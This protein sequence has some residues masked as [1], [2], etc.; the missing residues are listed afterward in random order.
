[1]TNFGLEKILYAEIID[2]ALAEDFGRGGDVTSKAVIPESRK[3]RA[4]II[5]RAEGRLAGIDVAL[6]AFHKLDP[7][8]ECL[9]I[10]EDGTRLVEGSVLV[11]IRGQTRAILSAER[12]ALNFLTHL[13]GIATLT[14]K[15]VDAVAG[16]GARIVDTRKTLPGLRVLEKYAVRCGGGF[17]HRSGLDDAILIKDNH[18]IAAG[19]VAEAIEACKKNLSHCRKIE[20]EVDTIA[21]L[22]SAL[23][24]APDIILLDNMEPEDLREAVAIIAGRAIAEASGGITLDSAAAIAAT[25]VDVL[26]IG[27]LTHSA[28]ALDLSLEL[29]DG[30]L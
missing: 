25:G 30:D 29:D 9:E 27:A 15:F 16:S 4:R 11:E 21:Q 13:S 14:G 22:K 18:I 26:S 23:E 6:E 12:V 1:M 2:R 28:P 8:I 24:A 20:V 5:S 19:G 7:H 10:L 3:G 17:N